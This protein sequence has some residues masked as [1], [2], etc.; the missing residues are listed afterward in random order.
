MVSVA[1]V[2][3]AITGW[4]PAAATV[5]EV[6][7]EPA[8]PELRRWPERFH[9]LC[10]VVVSVLPPRLG[11]VV[12]PTVVGFC[13][14][15]GFTFGLDMLIL[16]VLHGVVHA[17]AAVALTVAYACAFSLSFV[18]NRAL[19]F[20]SHAPRGRQIAIYVV[21]VAVNYLAFILGVSTL[22]TA[23][24]VPYLASR[25]VAGLCE[26]VYMYCAMRWIV[27]RP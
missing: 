24:G 10:L 12:P 17:P 13:L 8:R 15:N 21:V 20:R 2:G 1:A 16:T 26:A 19:N 6:S 23:M 14:L 7:S 9:R 22:L 5:V 11:S 3:P 27:F 25:I 18:L 4:T